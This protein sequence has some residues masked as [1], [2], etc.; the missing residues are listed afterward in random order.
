MNTQWSTR[1]FVAMLAIFVAAQGARAKNESE[2]DLAALAREDYVQQFHEI[3][4]ELSCRPWYGQVADQ[5][6]RQ[7]SLIL[8]DDRTPVDVVVRRTLALIKHLEAAHAGLSFNDERTKLA[9]I[10]AAA[11]ALDPQWESTWEEF[12][13]VSRWGSVGKW[14]DPKVVK[15]D[16]EE[17]RLFE[18]RRLANPKPLCDL[19]IEAGRISR[20]V[21]LRNP[22]LDFD[23]LLFV[24]RLRSEAV[25]HFEGHH[26]VTQ[27]EGAHALPG[28]GLYLLEAPFGN[29]PEQ[30][31]VLAQS[32]VERGRL[33]GHRLEG[34]SFLDPD[35]SFDGRSL[36]FSWVECTGSRRHSTPSG[37]DRGPWERGRC[38]HVF[39]VNLD[40]RELQQLTD[41]TWN[42]VHPIWM[43]DGSIVFIS[44][45][46]GGY[47]RCGGPL[48]TYTLHRMEADGRSLQTLS[49][50]ETNEWH[51]T[52]GHDGHIVYSRWDYVD[53]SDCIAH[54]PW[55]TTPDGRDPRALHG[56]F[57]E[58]RGFGR[59]DAEMDLQPI[60]GS[61]RFVA[62][63][64]PHHGHAFG[65]LIQLDF[66][67]PDDGNASQVQRITPDVA[68]PEA[69]TAV[70][71]ENQLLSPGYGTPWPLNEDFY[72]CCYKY[73]TKSLPVAR[74][75]LYLVDSLGNR[76]LLY[77]EEG[78]DSV[79]PIPVRPRAQPP[80]VSETVAFDPAVA[81]AG[82]GAVA[83]MNVYDGTLPWPEGTKIKTL[84]VVQIYPKS[85]YA[86]DRPY[87]SFGTESL[88]RGVLGTVPVEPDGSVHFSIPA[89]TPVYFQALD[90]EGRAVQSMR[91]ATYVKPGK[92]LVCAG[93][94]DPRKQAPV[95]SNGA[96]LAIRRPP[97]RLQPDVE[98]TNPVFFPT[99]IQPILDKHCAACHREKQACGFD[100]EIVTIDTPRSR[101][102]T[103]RWTRAY[104]SLAPFAFAFE[105]MTGR[106]RQQGVRTLPGEFGARASKLYQ[107]LQDGHY[108]VS[109]TDGE[110]HRII[111]WLDCNSNYFS[112][113]ESEQQQL[114]GRFV[115][116]WLE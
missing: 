89:D 87:V 47:A 90:D 81:Q 108:D 102:R 78:I 7:E 13:W 79:R 15:Q 60:P 112:A 71:K 69:E 63:A 43:P 75:G 44:E 9:E 6:L 41:G 99:L 20:R 3:E 59:P 36:L 29:K 113:Y 5:V 48:P 51:P 46:R 58:Q 25:S 72:L 61:H 109:L 88:V 56:N 86:M 21:A 42:D 104:A 98:G 107:L 106:E 100:T 27:Y 62:T 110:L 18:V 1:C 35:L 26:M 91:S 93:C 95:E 24:K 34:G 82:E 85:N 103:A 66:S 17:R 96:P 55:V 30:S 10:R 105:G 54:H 97:N 31:D 45:R 65:S 68:Y 80:A 38:Y 39:R 70:W 92:R 52:V 22:L 84:R 14:R 77:R 8:E 76:H 32:V 19:F 53:R 115:A 114:E 101:V 111:V 11:A 37:R 4:R 23:R 74:M 64:T 2:I 28:G 94:H 83:C 50:H 116:P 16:D 33:A 73:E 12:G 67:L 49:A 57:P 40:G